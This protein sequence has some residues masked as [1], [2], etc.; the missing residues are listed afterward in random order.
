MELRSTFENIL[1]NCNYANPPDRGSLIQTVRILFDSA[2]RI[3]NPNEN[4]L[5]LGSISTLEQRNANLT[6]LQSNYINYATNPMIQQEINSFSVSGHK[7]LQLL[8]QDLQNHGAGIKTK[9]QENII[10]RLYLGLQQK[11]R[12]TFLNSW[13]IPI[14]PQMEILARACYIR[15]MNGLDNVIPVEGDTG[16]GKTSFIFAFCTTYADMTRLPFDLNYNLVINEDKEYVTELLSKLDK[17]QICWLDEAGNQANRKLWYQVEAIEFI[18]YLTRLRVHGLTIPAIWPDLKDIDP[19]VI[20]RAAFTVSINKRGLAQVKALNKNKYAKD[21]QFVPYGAKNLVALTGNEA[22]QISENY[23][24]LN[25]LEIPY[26]EIPKE[27]WSRYDLR[28][29]ASLSVSGLKKRFKKDRFEI[30]SDYYTTFLLEIPPEASR[31]T[32]KQVNDYGVKIAYKLSFK[33]VA[34]RLAQATGRK[35]R[36]L[37]KFENDIPDMDNHGYILIDEYI[38]K[39]LDNIRHMKLGAQQGNDLK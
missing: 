30:A 2:S 21:K 6:R 31:I 23:D 7:F 1:Q 27:P 16:V 8:N 10:D 19:A 32:G 38:A 25:L 37:L 33:K 28:K 17:F 29:E 18:N 3:F 14:S 34:E 15:A 12:A 35:W 26:Y 5:L 24:L 4:L 11:R 9:K 39:Y 22:A 13:G 36:D 20:K